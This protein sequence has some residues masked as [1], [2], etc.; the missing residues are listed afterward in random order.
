VGTIGARLGYRGGDPLVANK[1]ARNAPTP[2]MLNTYYWLLILLT[3]DLN[4]NIIGPFDNKPANDAGIITDFLLNGNTTTQDRG[5]WAVGDGFI[6]ANSYNATDPEQYDLITTYFGADL[7]NRN[8][9]QFASVSDPTVDLLIYPAW[10]NGNPSSPKTLI[11]LYGMRN[12]CIW[13]NDVLVKATPLLTA[14]TGEYR[15]QVAPSGGPYYSGIFKDWDSGSPWKALVDGWDIYHLASQGDVNTIGRSAYFYRVFTNVWWKIKHDIFTPIVPLDV[16]TLNDGA[17]FN[18]VNIAGNP[19]YAQ[20]QAHIN[21]GL[22]RADRVEIKVYDVSGRLIRT[23]ADHQFTAGKHDIVWDGLDNGGRQVARGVYFTQ[24]KFANQGY[25][26]N[27]KL[28][29]LK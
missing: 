6:E 8:F 21:F 3:G 9:Q 10:Q 28:I 2:E 11:E 29:V 26:A 27:K 20:A 16:P 14:Y 15:K 5:I 4:S 12:Q 7:E 1:S 19:M 23:L 18:F 17:L 25:Q 24:V 22:A 13:T